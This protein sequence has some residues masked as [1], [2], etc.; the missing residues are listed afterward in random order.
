M[1]SIG[2]SSKPGRT[3]RVDFGWS[4]LGLALAGEFAGVPSVL[5]RYE[6]NSVLQPKSRHR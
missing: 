2:D 3:T 5:P 4:T 1:N 6:A